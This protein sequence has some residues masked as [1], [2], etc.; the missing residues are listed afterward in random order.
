[1]YLVLQPSGAKSW[2][3]RYR[4]NGIPRKLTIG[5]YPAVGLATARRRAQEALGDV[6]GGKDPAAAKKAV[7]EAAKAERADDDRRVARIAELFIDR[8]VKRSGKVGAG[9]AAEIERYLSDLGI[10]A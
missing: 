10:H 9:W 8:Y 4:A 1:M 3:L 2:A 5:P 6:A 7:R